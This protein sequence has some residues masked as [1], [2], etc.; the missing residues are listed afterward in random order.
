[1]RTDWTVRIKRRVRLHFVPIVMAGGA[2]LAPAHTAYADSGLGA[3]LAG[4]C[5]TCHRTDGANKGIPP[6]AGWP[7]ASFV[8]ALRAYKQKLRPNVVM[9][10][11]AA[12]LRD[13]EMDALATYF[14]AQ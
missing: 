5:V 1:M 2:L 14:A 11:I 8:A 4:E 10:T 13:D 12:R 7:E 3:Y 6:I 9:Q